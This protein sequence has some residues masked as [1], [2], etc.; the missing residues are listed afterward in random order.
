MFRAYVKYII[1]PM[2]F[3]FYISFHSL[4]RHVL[5]IYKIINLLTKTLEKVYS[6]S[7]HY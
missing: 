5:Y 1:S 2:Y 6:F 7:Y 4:A 3:M